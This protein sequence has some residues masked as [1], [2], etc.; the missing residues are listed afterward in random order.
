MD[1]TSE[2]EYD[3][4]IVT[5]FSL[6]FTLIALIVAF[7]LEG[8]G[9]SSLLQ[10]TAAI[11]VFGGTLGAVGVSFPGKQLKKFP[12][13]IMKAFKTKKDD[14]PVIISQLVEMAQKA[15]KEGLLSL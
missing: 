13:L 3:M 10:P 5:L 8:G 11:I 9:V 1:Y 6:I 4:D 15:R 2:R 12:R 7:V 14:R